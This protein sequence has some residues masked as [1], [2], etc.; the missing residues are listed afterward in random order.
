M[1]RNKL[2][3]VMYKNDVTLL[4]EL[5]I[6]RYQLHAP[7]CKHYR[8][9]SALKSFGKYFN[10]FF[11]STVH[12]A[13]GLSFTCKLYL[14]FLYFLVWINRYESYKICMKGQSDL[15]NSKY[16]KNE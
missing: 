10:I 13:P 8:K 3:I 4:N 16:A 11:F 14:T 15:W 2:L 12:A 6:N 9:N 1:M 7:L 5:G